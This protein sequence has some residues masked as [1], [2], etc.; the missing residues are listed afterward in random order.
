MSS[1]VIAGNTSGTVTLQA[2][3]VSGSTVLT[4]PNVSGT[5]V[6]TTGGN[7]TSATNI[8]DGVAGQLPYQSS[9][10]V[11]AFV[12]NGTSGQFLSSNGSSPPTWISAPSTSGGATVTNPMS[13]NITLTS[14]SNR[15]QVLTPDAFNRRITLP[16]ATTIS[17]TGGPIFVI[18]NTVTWYPVAIMDSSGNNVGWVVSDYQSQVYLTSTASATG[19]WII[20]T[21][22]PSA[23]AG[24]YPYGPTYLSS[25]GSVPQASTYTATNADGTVVVLSPN[26]GGQYQWSFDTRA[27]KGNGYSGA[28]NF[29]SG[30][31]VAETGGAVALVALSSGV[32]VTFYSDQTNDQLRC[33]ACSYSASGAITKGIELVIISGVYAGGIFSASAIDSTR[34]L[35]TYAASGTGYTRAQIITVGGTTCTAGTAVTVVSVASTNYTQCAVLSSTLAHVVTNQS[36]YD[37]TLGTST[38]TVNGNVS[39]GA[40]HYGI[41]ANTSTSSIAF[42]S[43]GSGGVI[44]KVAT[45]SG[46]TPTL[47]TASGVLSSN[48][49]YPTISQIKQGLALIMIGQGPNGV[50]QAPFSR[51]GVS[52][53]IPVLLSQG[54]APAVS[55]SNY[56][57]VQTL[58]GLGMMLIQAGSY[59]NNAYAFRK[60][61][62]TGGI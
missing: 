50:T 55:L 19:N 62:I 20:K 46:G 4:L 32:T 14:S 7:A 48:S 9:P 35:V 24:I 33:F 61:A 34:V 25:T 56:Y 44:A 30:L 54:T 11:T 2:P 3:A 47:G 27:N 26:G 28:A 15:V 57:Y 41:C 39:L 17:A 49:S 10:G 51:V 16:D 8:S 38:I 40:T 18:Q 59:S 58:N 6:T 45:S 23:D 12:T 31:Y 60:I 1:V 22:N 21:G 29:N 5:I 53:G 37:L 13:S 42:Y 43:D 52:S 36:V